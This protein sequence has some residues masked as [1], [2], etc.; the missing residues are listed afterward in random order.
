[1]INKGV[2]NIDFRGL[3]DGTLNLILRKNFEKEIKEFAPDFKQE[4]AKNNG[5]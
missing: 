4:F 2:S 3:Q 5:N 1:L